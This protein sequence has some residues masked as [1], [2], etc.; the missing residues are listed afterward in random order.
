MKKIFVTLIPLIVSSIVNA[1]IE[2]LELAYEAEKV[3][4]EYIT[5][6]K[7]GYIYPLNCEQ[8]TEKQYEFD[9]TLIIT[10]RGSPISLETF[11]VEYPKV[12]FPTFFT[13]VN[14]KKV[15]RVIY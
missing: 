4:V 15:T 3:R 6:T 2:V 8:C 5:Q 7:R 12:Q 14:S 11:L 13:P 9:S 1:E 10:K